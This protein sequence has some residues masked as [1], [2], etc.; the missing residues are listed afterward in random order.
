MIP[1]LRGV[2]VRAV[3]IVG[4]VAVIA[5]AGIVAVI[6]VIGVIA[7]I[8]VGIA[9]TPPKWGIDPSEPAA[10]MPRARVGPAPVKSAATAVKS[11]PVMSGIGHL[12]VNDSGSK[13]QYRRRGTP[14]SPSDGLPV[15][16]ISSL[17]T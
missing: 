15:T 10:G 8:V 3:A 6:P 2:G 5:G 7:V 4:I 12:W 1:G 17:S 13:K 16:V 14:E 9:V 11:P